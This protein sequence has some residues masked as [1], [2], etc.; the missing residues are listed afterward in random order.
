M[1]SHVVLRATDRGEVIVPQI[2][3][4]IGAGVGER[5]QQCAQPEQ[6]G[7][8]HPR[9]RGDH[10]NGRH[11]RP[12]LARAIF[13]DVSFIEHARPE[14]DEQRQQSERHH[15]EQRDLHAR[16][17]V[18]VLAE[19]DHELRREHEIAAAEH[20]HPEHVFAEMR[21]LA[22]DLEQ[23]AEA[24]RLGA[25]DRGVLF[26]QQ[27]EFPPDPRRAIQ[28]CRQQTGRR[29]GAKQPARVEDLLVERP[30]GQ[31]RRECDGQRAHD[32]DAPGVAADRRARVVGAPDRGP[33]REYSGP[34]DTRDQDG[35]HRESQ[36]AERTW[37]HA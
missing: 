30:R 7:P 18:Q 26:G 21:I 8:T 37:R 33:H 27:C 3:A 11:E 1:H 31:C 34:H 10:R 32:D 9:A 20:A 35:G 2:P 4:E 28:P 13:N 36:S 16:G 5:Q 24:E 17:E 14:R 6:R 22:Q 15:R 19:D 12:T 29:A 23:H 25:P